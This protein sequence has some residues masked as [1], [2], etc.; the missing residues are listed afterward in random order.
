MND[1]THLVGAAV[2]SGFLALNVLAMY[3]YMRRHVSLDPRSSMNH[4]VAERFD[5]VEELR[6]FHEQEHSSVGA[7]ANAALS[8]YQRA[9]ARELEAMDPNTA[10]NYPQPTRRFEQL[11]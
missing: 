9:M 8:R 7:R 11:V 2:I 3:L 5:S 10:R 1:I 6:E 4:A